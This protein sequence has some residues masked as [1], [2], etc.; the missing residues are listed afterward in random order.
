[1]LGY[2]VRRLIF[3]GVTIA[4]ISVICFVVI[5]LPPGD[6]IDEFSQ[7]LMDE[8]HEIITEAEMDALREFY[9]IDRPVFVQYAKWIWGVIRADF[10]YSYQLGV[11]IKDLLAER[12]M[13]TIV[14]TGVTVLLTWLMSIPI[15]IYSALRQHSVGDYTVTFFGFL[16]LA[17]P[18]F[19]L[20]L[21]L[22]FIAFRYLE[23]SV[24]GLFSDEYVRG[25]LRGELQWMGWSPQRLW[26]MMAHLWIP[27][28]V[29]GTAG[30]AGLVRIMR[31]NL[32][33]ELG[34]AYVTTARSKGLNNWRVIAKYPVRIA[35][36]PLV[37]A[38]GSLLPSLF[39]GSVI[40]SV[41]LSLPTVGPLLLRALITQDMYVAGTIILFLGTLTVIGTMISDIFLVIV[42][43]RIKYVE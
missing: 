26:N 29:L 22:M 24:G 43:P 23:I 18:D 34:K 4:L 9:G 10:G 32:L 21:L 25:P 16:G 20:G 36:N 12:L 27:A 13:F 2:I 37:S 30:T 41:V 5:Q 11:P 17:V 14:L 33:D 42:D 28:V 35:I 7:R 31:N 3:G 15:G 39:G 1:M 6:Y 19:L 8:Q 38:M 40:V